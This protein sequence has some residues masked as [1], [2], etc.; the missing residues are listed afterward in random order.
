MDLASL[1][2]EK[3]RAQRGLAPLEARLPFALS[4][5]PAAQSDLAA[6][7]IRRLEKDF[8]FHTSH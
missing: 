8:V 6:A 1:V 3:T 7:M 4:G 2:A 5:H